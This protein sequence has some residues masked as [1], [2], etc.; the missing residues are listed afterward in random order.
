M[1]VGY[2][3]YSTIAD[4]VDHVEVVSDYVLKVYLTEVYVDFK[5]EILDCPIVPKHIWEPIVTASGFDPW[6]YVPP[7]EVL[8]VGNGPFVL[9]HYSETVEAEF[10]AFENF[11]RGRPYIDRLLMPIITSPDAMLLAL[12]AGEIDVHMWTVPL[13]PESQSSSNF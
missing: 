1:E 11:A 9:D 7:I 6:T 13:E 5:M 2:P 3:R 10:V 8:K 12:K 4:Y